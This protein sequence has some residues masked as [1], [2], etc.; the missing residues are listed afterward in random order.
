[1]KMPT[2]KI[3]DLAEVLIDYSGE[4]S[5]E[6]EV[7]GIRSGEKLHEILFSEY[8]S[9]YTVNYDDQY[10]V[11]VPS[12]PLVKLHQHYSKFPKVALK[13]YQSDQSLISKDEIRKMLIDGGFIS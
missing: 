13:H 2:C 7:T 1:M 9:K 8:E 10:Y 11:I 4:T 5:V 12:L 3:L 6:I